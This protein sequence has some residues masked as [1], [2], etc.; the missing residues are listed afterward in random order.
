MAQ[1]A[2]KWLRTTAAAGRSRYLLRCM[3]HA[4]VYFAVTLPRRD[5]RA[6]M[7]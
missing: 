5:A 2:D 7:P 3:P 6:H 4:E 1:D